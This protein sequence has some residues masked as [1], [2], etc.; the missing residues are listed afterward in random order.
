MQN[1]STIRIVY[2]MQYAIK[3]KLKGHKVLTMMPNPKDQK[4]QCWVFENDQTF[5]SDLHLII[6]EG[7]KENNYV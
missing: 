5:D 3:M 1:T 2:K 4:Y 7:R 6:A